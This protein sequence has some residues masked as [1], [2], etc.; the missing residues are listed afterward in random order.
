MFITEERK[1]Q[2]AFSDPYYVAAMTHVAPKDSGITE[3]TNEA[4]AGKVDRRPVGHHPGRRTCRPPIPTPTS[5]ST[6]PRTR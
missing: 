3:F 5:G 4:M 6:R 2:V 1:Q